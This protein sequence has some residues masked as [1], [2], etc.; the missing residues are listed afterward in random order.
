MKRNL[1]VALAAIAIT[2]SSSAAIFAT[3]G[4]HVISDP[5]CNKCTITNSERICGKC[6]GFL[7]SGTMKK[8]NTKGVSY[9]ATFTCKKCKHS[10]IGGC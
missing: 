4:W 7:E 10:A 2:L 9:E 1:L 3:K 6:G 5:N 8:S